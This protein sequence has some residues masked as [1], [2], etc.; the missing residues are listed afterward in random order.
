M[1]MVTNQ[2]EVSSFEIMVV[3]FS[4]CLQTFGLAIVY[5][6]GHPGTD[7][8]FMNE[9]S[10]CLENVSSRHVK[11]FLCGD[12]NYWLDAPASKPYT[13]EFLSLLSANNI[14][15]I[16]TMPTDFSG[17]TLG[18]VLAPIESDFI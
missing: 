6:P 1:K 12:F 5:H 4:L 3:S 10:M 8:T 13:E 2:I 17:H 11:L 16:A 9:F 18:L 7:R 15:N 14:K